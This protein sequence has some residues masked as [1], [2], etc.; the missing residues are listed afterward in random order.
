[1]WMSREPL[2]RRR[3]LSTLTTGCGGLG[4]LI[5]GVRPAHAYTPIS[6]KAPARISGLVRYHGRAPRPGK[7]KLSGDCA[8][9]RRFNLKEEHLLVSKKGGLRNVAVFL[10]RVTRGKALPSKTPVMAERRCTFVPHVLTVTAGSK[11]L[12]HNQD[13]VLN[14]FHAIA[15]PSGR[16]LFNL[17]TPKKD[18]KY[19]RRIRPTGVI[20][21]RCDVHPW[22]RAYII[23]VDHPYHTV[24]DSDG[25]FALELIPPGDYTLALWH[26]K[27]GA[28]KKQLSLGPGQHLRLELTFR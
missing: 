26:E 13:P 8:Y 25:S 1:M 10:Q 28:K 18:M 27:L 16:T 19:K 9:C 22:E 4:V 11:I 15:R 21:M 3:F 24:T 5:A 2:D 20:E 14:T 6:I 7:V 17:G 23:S 12:L